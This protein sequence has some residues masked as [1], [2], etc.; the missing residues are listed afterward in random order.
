MEENKEVKNIVPDYY[1]SH[2]IM[3]SDFI[4]DWSLNFNRGSAVKYIARAGD[5]I[6]PGLTREEMLIK[7]LTKARTLLDREI[8]RIQRLVTE[9]R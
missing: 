5:K 2:N 9:S 4:E 8:K 6:E 1:A 7:D 3:P